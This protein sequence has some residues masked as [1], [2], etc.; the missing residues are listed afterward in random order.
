MTLTPT[1]F[2]RVGEQHAHVAFALAFAVVTVTVTVTVSVT[3]TVTDQS[4]GPSLIDLPI[5]WRRHVA[6]KF[7]ACGSRSGS[8]LRILF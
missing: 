4:I 2:F 7:F 8:G 1:P 6:S 3:V 5:A